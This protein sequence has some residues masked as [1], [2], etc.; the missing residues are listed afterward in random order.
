MITALFLGALSVLIVLVFR[1]QVHFL[2]Y[3]GW[4]QRAPQFSGDASDLR[5]SL[6]ALD[7]SEL[8][9]ALP[10]D[11]ASHIY[12][13]DLTRLGESADVT[14]PES[15]L[16]KRVPIGDGRYLQAT[17]P[18]Y[19]ALEFYGTYGRLPKD[20]A[21]ILLA[22][23]HLPSYD[24]SPDMEELYSL[25]EGV[26]LATG[27]MMESF[28]NGDSYTISIK[29]NSGLGKFRRLYTSKTKASLKIQQGFSVI[30]VGAVS[31]RVL[32]RGT[33]WMTI[34]TDGNFSPASD[35]TGL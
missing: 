1:E 29:P 7:V 34:E 16:I 21:E 19:A 25:R 13:G 23:G 24:G 30:V 35:F 4:E 31:S 5:R 28:T 33:I 15:L 17:Q 20:G 27:R 26:N 22:K 11:E 8:I 10:V 12:P 9:A 32:Y 6:A 3:W 2:K 14:R 18:I